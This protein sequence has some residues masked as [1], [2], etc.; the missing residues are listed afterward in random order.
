MKTGIGDFGDKE[1]QMNIISKVRQYGSIGSIR[2][3]IKK[4]RYS[5]IKKYN[6]IKHYFYEIKGLEIGGPSE[7]FSN[8]GYIPLYKI[9]KCL[10]GIN[11]SNDTIWTG[12]M[13]G[14][15]L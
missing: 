6:N 9:V 13:R 8:N 12:K 7:M 4:F 15:I 5:R 1:K 3:I 11:F 10:D 14:G 2:K